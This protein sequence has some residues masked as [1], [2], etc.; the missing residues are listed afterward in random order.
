M[1]GR[2]EQTKKKIRNGTVEVPRVPEKKVRKF[3]AGTKWSRLSARASGIYTARVPSPCRR[4][5][6]ELS[7]FPKVN[8]ARGAPRGG[9]DCVIA[10]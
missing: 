10:W 5:L 3:Q 7:R 9:V 1:G 6:V 2:K 4:S 8:V